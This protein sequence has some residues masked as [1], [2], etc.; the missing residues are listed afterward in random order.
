MQARRGIVPVAKLGDPAEQ[1]GGVV[2]CLG[3]GSLTRQ[4][5]TELLPVFSG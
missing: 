4:I 5:S 2:A 1:D 3:Y